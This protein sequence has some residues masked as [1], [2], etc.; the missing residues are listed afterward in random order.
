MSEIKIIV[1]AHKPYRIP[2][3]PIYLPVQVGAARKDSI[4]FQR[5]DEGENK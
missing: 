3:D 2:N 5:D 1:A 4:G